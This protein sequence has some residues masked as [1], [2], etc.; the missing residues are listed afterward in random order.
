VPSRFLALAVLAVAIL[1][2]RGAGALLEWSPSSRLRTGLA[3]LLVLFVGADILSARAGLLGPPRC[4]GVS[5]P[6][7]A[8]TGQTFV[9]LRQSPAIA[10]CGAYS[11]LAP[12]VSAGV[13]IIDA[14]EPLCPRYVGLVGRM[15]GLFGLGEQGYQGEAWVEGQGLV[16]IVARTQNTL[17]LRVSP[18]ASGAVVLNQNWDRGWSSDGGSLF[19]DSK[20]RLTLILTPGQR[21]YVLRYRPPYFSLSVVLWA[22]GVL[23]LGAL[24]KLK[25]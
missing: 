20:R 15:P 8:P 13:A 17:S 22:L 2:A 10:S 1:A 5:W 11:G 23:V 19:Q 6:A 18:E 14:Y 7:S 21:T 9:T 16:E 25:S 3:L 12:A 4:A 24:W